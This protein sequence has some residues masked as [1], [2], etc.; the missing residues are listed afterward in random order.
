MGVVEVDLFD[1]FEDPEKSADGW[2]SLVRVLKQPQNTE[3]DGEG[4]INFKI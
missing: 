1:A 4:S 3:V 2:V